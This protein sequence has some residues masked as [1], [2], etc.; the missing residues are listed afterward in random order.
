MIIKKGKRSEFRCLGELREMMKAKPFCFTVL[1]DRL[2]SV[3]RAWTE[4]AF[5]EPTLKEIYFPEEEDENDDAAG[6]VQRL[7][8]S[9]TALNQEGED[10]LDESLRLANGIGGSSAKKKRSTP[11][12]ARPERTS[13]RYSSPLH[14][15]ARGGIL[16]K[17]RKTATRLEFGDSQEQVVQRADYDSEEVSEPDDGAVLS[18]LPRLAARADSEDSISPKKPRK[19]QKKKYDGR[20]VWSDE[21]KR[22]I[23]EGIKQI[24]AGQW[25]D[26]K[27]LYEVILNDRTS[28]QIKVR[29]V[30]CFCVKVVIHA[31]RQKTVFNKPSLYRFATLGLLSHHETKRRV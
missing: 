14:K 22:A 6:A 9:R 31:T 20:R 24:G 3:M 5:E 7:R 18:D 4:D 10:P 26:I 28:G 30:A 12:S 25:A 8:R 23:K 2:N 27:K 29:G 11:G 17:K 1:D 21:E 13:S 15:R 19:S 16:L